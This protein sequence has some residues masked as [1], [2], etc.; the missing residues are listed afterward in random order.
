MTFTPGSGLAELVLPPVAMRDEIYATV[1]MDGR[2]LHASGLDGGG[3]W[4]GSGTDS[5]EMNFL[6]VPKGHKLDRETLRSWAQQVLDDA[7]LPAAGTTV[8]VRWTGT[9]NGR[10]SAL[11]TLRPGDGGVLA[12]VLHGSDGRYRQ[13]YRALFP[14]AGFDGRPIAW[15]MRGE[16]S[17]DRTGTVHVVAPAGTTR[18]TVTAAGAAPAPVTLDATGFGTL[19]LAPDQEATVTAYDRDGRETG[20]TP[21]LPFE[22]NMG[23]RRGAHQ[24]PRSRR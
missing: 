13:D 24:K 2:T 3:V 19:T 7:R 1:T 6:A 10:P 18:V 22:N 5:A 23:G 20:S 8:T 9:V 21:V 12:Y 17:D 15:R 4:S 14:A 16:G 11:L